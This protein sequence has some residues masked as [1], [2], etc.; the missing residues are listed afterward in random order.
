MWGSQETAV[1]LT[2]KPSNWRKYEKMRNWLYTIITLVS[3]GLQRHV[4]PLWKALDIL[5]Q[6]YVKVRYCRSKIKGEKITYMRK[7]T[8]WSFCPWSLIYDIRPLHSFDR[9][10][11]ELSIEG[12]HISVA[13]RRPEL[14]RYKVKSSFF[15]YFLRFGGL[16]VKYTVVSWL[17]HIVWDPY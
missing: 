12:S 7:I 10:C 11:Q 14:W 16:K 1:Y 3:F 6:S 9:G 4:T 5:Y 8:T 2:F 15:L 13:Q 17:P